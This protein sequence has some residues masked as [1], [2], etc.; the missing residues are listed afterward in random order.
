MVTQLPPLL[1]GD[2]SASSS[3]FE[4][5][6][7]S[8]KGLSHFRKKILFVDTKDDENEAR[9]S[10]L[11]SKL[12]YIAHRQELIYD[13]FNKESL[14]H[15]KFHFAPHVTILK[16]RAKH[17]V[18]ED[19]KTLFAEA[20]EEQTHHTPFIDAYKEVDFG[21]QSFDCLELCAMQGFSLP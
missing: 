8:L 1:Y 5:L 16:M 9:L 11:A 10:T 12:L 13:E 20:H 2:S 14:A 19:L 21:D 4:Q 6:S 15:E 18:N 3:S 17:I 7:L